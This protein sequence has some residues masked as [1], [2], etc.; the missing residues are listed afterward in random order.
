MLTYSN[1]VDDKEKCILATKLKIMKNSE[2]MEMFM[3]K[4]DLYNSIVDSNFSDVIFYSEVK[5]SDVTKRNINLI[6]AAN[7]SGKSTFSTIIENGINKTP[8]IE[9]RF[10]KKTSSMTIIKNSNNI[11]KVYRYDREFASKSADLYK[12]ELVISPKNANLI[13]KKREEIDNIETLLLEAY[14][15]SDSYKLL[16]EYKETFSKTDLE[17]LS[18]KQLKVTHTKEIYKILS[19]KWSDDDG[20]DV[21]GIE[22]LIDIATNDISFLNNCI[23][24][25]ENTIKLIKA[26]FP[27]IDGNDVEF[28]TVLL[29]YLIDYPSKVLDKNCLMCG[30]TNITN[31]ILNERLEYIRGRINDYQNSLQNNKY[32]NQLTAFLNC[33]FKSKL[34][35]DL[36]EEL[37]GKRDEELVTVSINIGTKISAL[38]FDSV[39]KRVYEFIIKKITSEKEIRK[40]LNEINTLTNELEIIQ[41]E[42]V[43]T[44]DVEAKNRFTNN[45]KAMN[46]KY[47]DKMK[48]SL[49][50][51]STITISC[52]DID[53]SNLYFEILSESEKSILSFALFLA[54]IK[55]YDK[56]I[57]IIDDPIDS[58]DQKNKWFIL[59]K[60]HE[61]FGSNKAILIILTHDLD[62]S[63]ALHTIDSSLNYT[64]YLLT[65]SAIKEV[66][67]PSLYF[68]DMSKFIHSV[69]TDIGKKSVND[70]EKYIIPIGFFL[71]YLCKNQAKHLKEIISSDPKTIKR[72]TIKQIG[73]TNVSNNFVHYE[74]NVDSSKLLDDLCQILNITRKATNTPS[75]ICKVIASDLLI[76]SIII[77]IKLVNQ[78]D[79]DITKVLLALL[80]RNI[81]EKKMKLANNLIDG[82]TLTK[83]AEQYKEFV[84]DSDSLYLFYNANKFMIDEFAH[85]E[86]G[87]D[88]LLTYDREY[89]EEKL[90][91]IKM[92]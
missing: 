22:E 75:Y 88:A 76:E 10:T 30:K 36:Q 1:R 52:E 40:I 19:K 49:N 31:V 32:F 58:H 9:N 89:I 90:K 91:I 28:Y 81:V 83:C 6:Y 14:K 92:I 70:N 59:D 68:N 24:V 39:Y 2:N 20:L 7:A 29:N 12:G 57:V 87:V 84:S 48:V 21:L 53:I 46:F 61:Y 3:I 79:E 51:D 73:F 62:V 86:S 63:K 45:L 35:K 54:V 42:N 66:K 37:L 47:A 34:F 18:L 27:E 56:S 33:D 23:D 60:I 80:I 50:A 15:K 64:N 55:E 17:K 8:F 69:V 4:F 82:K 41:K 78:Y 77:D 67:G 11:N 43:K 65:K 13:V 74:P 25:N 72:C 44:I 71:R 5:I 16:K 85:I 26:N 38:N